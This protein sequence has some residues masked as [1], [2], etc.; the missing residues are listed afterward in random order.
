MNLHLRNAVKHFAF[1]NK[2]PRKYLLGIK[3]GIKHN[4]P[5][6]AEN[7]VNTFKRDFCSLPCFFPRNSMPPRWFMLLAVRLFRPT[8]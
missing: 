8:A 6:A 5:T 7:N 3:I 4:I 2:Q 1:S